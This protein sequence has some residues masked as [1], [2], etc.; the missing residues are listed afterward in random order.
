V[1]C[2]NPDGEVA[3]VLDTSWTYG[4]NEFTIWVSQRE[5]AEQTANIMYEGYAQ[6]WS[7]GYAYSVSAGYVY[8]YGVD[9]V[10]RDGGI[11][12]QASQA[13]LLQAIAELA[14]DVPQQC[15][16]Q[17]ANAEWSALADLGV[18]DPRG[19]IPA[20]FV[21][22]SVWAQVFTPP[23][24]GCDVPDD[25]DLPVSFGAQWSSGDGSWLSINIYRAYNDYYGG[26]LAEVGYS[27]D[28]SVS[29]S[30]GTYRFDVYGNNRD[31]GI[32][33]ATLQAIA[34]A[35]DPQ[36]DNACLLV[37]RHLTEAELE[38]QGIGT[39]DAPGGYVLESSRAVASEP[40]ANCDLGVEV[41]NVSADWQFSGPNGEH[42]SASAWL[43]KSY[44]SDGS[45][46][47]SIGQGYISW[48]GP[49]GA[50]YSVSGWSETDGP[51]DQETLI[52]VALSMDPTLNVDRLEDGDG[53][54]RPIPLAEPAVDTPSSE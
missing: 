46:Y 30:N 38:A 21:E 9:D 42:V 11:D 29:W 48:I 34:R 26:P 17:P 8:Y 12:N 24:E 5:S 31:S 32:G 43:D 54:G 41:G 39:A 20:G 37:E 23:A 16:Y 7:Q 1:D 3:V 51:V 19:A 35:L 50:N 33:M 27:N 2:E 49:N 25:V 28:Y 52:G 40:N 13:V 15:F 18:G 22:E 53:G 14:P 45:W 36:F 10:A 44:R 47:G 6:F 4:D